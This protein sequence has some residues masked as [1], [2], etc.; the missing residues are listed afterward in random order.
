MRQP[1][2]LV[3]Q[4]RLLGGDHHFVKARLHRPVPNVFLDRPA[5]DV[6]LLQYEADLSPEQM[7]IVFGN[8]AAVKKDLARGRRIKF[9]QEVEQ[10][11][12]ARAREPDKSDRLAGRYR[13]VYIEQCLRTVWIG[14][15][16]VSQLE[17]ALEVLARD[18]TAVLDR[19]I[20]VQYFEEPFG[21]S[22]R[23]VHLI[24]YAVKLSDRR[25]YVI[26]EQYVEHDRP[27]RHLLIEDEIGR[28]DDDQDDTDLFDKGFH[29]IEGIVGLPLLQLG[30]DE[31]LLQLVL[32]LAFVL[33]AHKRFNNND[34]FN[35]VEEAVR[36]LFPQSPQPAPNTFQQ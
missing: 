27:D 26:K 9:A 28:E 19:V 21:V 13:H 34:R 25:R 10:R 32:L 15:V 7:R 16:Y 29:R 31:G 12:L 2:D 35:N 3:V 14:K 8:V 24:V 5:K 22:H 36:L 4:V 17:L 33:L 18:R 23:F 20:S 11:G 30:F 6:I 1:H